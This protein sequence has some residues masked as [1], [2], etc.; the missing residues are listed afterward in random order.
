ME[1][2]ERRGGQETNQ[3]LDRILSLTPRENDPYVN[4]S[5]AQALDDAYLALHTPTGMTRRQYAN[6]KTHHSGRVLGVLD[7][8]AR[9]VIF[10]SYRANRSKVYVDL[11][12]HRGT[13]HI[14][15]YSSEI[16]TGISIRTEEDNV[17]SNITYARYPSTPLWPG[18]ECRLDL[19]YDSDYEHQ[20][21]SGETCRKLDLKYLQPAGPGEVPVDQVWHVVISGGEIIYLQKH[22]IAPR[23]VTGV[24]KEKGDTDGGNDGDDGGDDNPSL[25]P[26]PISGLDANLKERERIDIKR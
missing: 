14:G 11:P 21:G 4:V 18:W 10:E 23:N 15:I 3:T 9:R 16:F 20:I 12:K 6:A 24:T 7:S 1:E 17:H 26:G 19:E 2:I 8:F 5:L 13:T 22:I 25:P